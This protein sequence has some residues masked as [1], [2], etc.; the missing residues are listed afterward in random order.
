VVSEGVATT[1]E[2]SDPP[3]RHVQLTT[4]PA[5]FSR[6][7]EGPPVLLVHGLPGSGRDFRYLAPVL[8]R[9]ATVYRVDMPGFGQTP[10]ST[11]TGPT[12][13][14][15]VDHLQRMLDAL[16]LDRLLVVG[17]SMGAVLACALTVRE[18][19]RVAALGLISSPGLR[20]HRAYLRFNP[21]RLSL[22][23]RSPLGPLLRT[24]MR[25]G[26]EAGGFSRHFTDDELALTIHQVAQVSFADHAD[27]VARLAVPTGVYW[28]ADDPMIEDA[29][30]RELADAAPQGPRMRYPDGGH[31]PQKAHARELGDSLITLLP[32]AAASAPAARPSRP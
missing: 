22:L 2:P 10:A 24:P 1:L 28:C 25:R 26:F 13:A 6:Q 30:A 23:L 19:H 8:A 16:A 3:K 20:P 15:R 17:H 18:S 12:V 21:R 32:G 14:D 27:D 4:G 9:A 5:A 7:G 31:N 11:S 29:I